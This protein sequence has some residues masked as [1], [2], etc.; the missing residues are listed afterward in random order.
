MDDTESTNADPQATL[1]EW[2]RTANLFWAGSSRSAGGSSSSGPAAQMG[3][4]RVSPEVLSS[5]M[6]T[7]GTISSAM[8]EPSALDA[9]YRGLAIVPD[10]ISNVLLSGVQGFL[11]IQGQLM[12]KMANLGSR[13]EAYSFKHLDQEAL[14]AWSD[15]Y[16]KELRRYFN[17][18]QLG[19]NRFYQERLNQAFDKF[20]I[21]TVALIEFMNLLGLPVE[22]SFK[23]LQDQVDK[24]TR[25]GAVPEDPQEFYRM[26]IKILE[27]HF[28][29]LFK[30]PEYTSAL[31][32]TIQALGEFI[33]ARNQ[34]LQDALQSLPI[35]TSR[36]MDDLYE[37]LYVLKKRVKE[38]EKSLAAK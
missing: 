34:M 5:I 15:L 10:M 33:S 16:E 14:H 32:T 35:P 1:L 29:T 37:E 8:S 22:N 21:F 38:L 4:E 19:L 24:L 11:S 13:P 6:R 9:L 7:W 23:V 31:T 20:N 17:I 27:G 2:L 12:E 26:W 25:E 30:S 28:M 36:D 3:S 18:P